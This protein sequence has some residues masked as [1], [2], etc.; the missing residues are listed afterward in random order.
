[1]I[2]ASGG[3]NQKDQDEE[4]YRDILQGAM[5]SYRTQVS[6]RMNEVMTVLSIVATIM[7]PLGMLTGLHGTDFEVLPGSKGPSSFWVFVGSMLAL[8]AVATVFFK[9]RKWL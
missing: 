7:L 6:S 1:V 4:T 5:D 9:L 3:A 2:Q 8:A